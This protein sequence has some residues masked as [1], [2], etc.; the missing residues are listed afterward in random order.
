MQNRSPWSVERFYLFHTH[1]SLQWLGPKD[2]WNS[3]FL[4]L[5]QQ[6][7]HGILYQTKDVYFHPQSILQIEYND[8]NFQD[9]LFEYSTDLGLTWA[10]ISHEN[11]MKFAPMKFRDQ[12]ITYDRLTMTFNV[13]SVVRFRFRCRAN[14]LRYLYLGNPCPM[15]CYGTVRCTNGE[16]QPNDPIVPLVCNDCYLFM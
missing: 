11:Q 7:N 9:H 8:T 13:L 2:P 14:H 3:T 12:N 10:V 6:T 15:N 4:T 1:S 16:C 5:T